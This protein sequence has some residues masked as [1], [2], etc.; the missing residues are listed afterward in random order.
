M[1]S[2]SLGALS[3]LSWFWPLLRL[4]WGSAE[5][6]GD[7]YGF[8]QITLGLCRLSW[9][10]LGVS[11]EFCFTFMVFSVCP[12]VAPMLSL[13]AIFCA[14]LLPPLPTPPTSPALPPSPLLSHPPLLISPIHQAKQLHPLWTHVLLNIATRFQA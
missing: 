12:C 5:L 6:F 11:S 14:F 1:L 8:A 13:F 10:C 4:S 9:A 7:F 2:W 3:G